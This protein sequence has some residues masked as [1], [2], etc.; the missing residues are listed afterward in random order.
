MRPKR[1]ASV[2]GFPQVF[3]IRF[4]SGHD[5]RYRDF[6]LF[7]QRAAAARRAWAR[8]ASADTPSQRAF[9]PLGPPFLPPMR[10][11]A[12]NAASAAALSLTFDRLIIA[13]V[14]RRAA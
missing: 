1:R 5:A 14:A 8:R 3:D 10:P 11:S 6:F 13:T 12:R 9:P 7:D 2:V 4:A